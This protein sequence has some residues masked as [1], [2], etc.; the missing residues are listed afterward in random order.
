MFKNLFK[1]SFAYTVADVVNKAIP[2][3]MLPVLTRYLTPDDY[4]LLSL[5]SVFLSISSVF[6]GL[7]IHGVINVNFFNMQKRKFREFVGNCIIILSASTILVFIFISLLYPV[8]L[9]KTNLD[10]KWQFLV[11]LVAFSQFLT[12]INLALWL[13]ERRAISYG[14]YQISQTFLNA[15]LSLV[16]II[17]FKMNWEGQALSISAAS[18]LF[19]LISLAFIIKRQYLSIKFN[20]S[21]IKEALTF[22][23]SLIPHQLSGLVLTS[24]DRLF[25]IYMTTEAATGIYTLAFQ[26]GMII[27]LIL[28]AFN[29]AWAPYLYK[30]LS[31]NPT[32][33]SKRQIVVFT[34]IYFI[35]V[36]VFSI[37]I[38]YLLG[39][40]VPYFLGKKFIDVSEY[41]VY[42][43]VYFAVY[44]M[45]Y[46]VVNYLFYVKKTK[47]LSLITFLS[48]LLHIALLYIFIK[49]FGIIGAIQASII[50]I[51][52]MFLCVW[53]AANKY[54]KMPWGLIYGK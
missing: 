40:F 44:G 28:G 35:V 5:F 20:L 41:V 24:V 38:G 13:A 52:I 19:G 15:T 46:M 47:I 33:K 54:Y 4:G 48:S 26:L 21:Y 7:S 23:I 12:S 29:K 36:F 27:E 3:F 34:Y 22:G 43:A 16:M 53:Y 42:F 39:L 49:F 10:L 32:D 45:Y 31:N 2:F 30:I 51:L 17:G 37:F 18:I 50:T 9:Y 11:V 14:V 25:L 6:V 1:Y 8:I